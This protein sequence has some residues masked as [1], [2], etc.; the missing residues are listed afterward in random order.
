[1]GAKAKKIELYLHNGTLN[2]LTYVSESDGWDLGGI[3][4]SCPRDSVDILLNDD[5]CDK[6]GVYLLISSDKV[7]V[8]QSTDLKKRIEQHKIGK[9][10]WEKV[11]LLTSKNDELN[12]S[13]ITYLES[14]LIVKAKSCGTL[15]CENKTDGNKNN[16]DKFTKI[17]L[18]QY[19]EEAL[20]ILELIGVDVFKKGTKQSIIRSIPVNSEEKIEMRAKGE[21]LQFLENKGIK[22]GKTR[23]YAKYQEKKNLFWANPLVEYTKKEWWIILNDQVDKEIHILKVPA[24]TFE[25]CYPTK[26]GKLVVRK[27]KPFYIDLNLYKDTYIDKRTGCD[28]SKF[29]VNTIKY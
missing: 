17:L 25:T 3:L 10:W 13:Y 14:E 19:L 28:F 1:M 4:Y 26:K 22:I 7:Y 18:D 15:D 9:D 21:V 29:L 20:F 11:I 8:G 27:D 2:G 5:S 12:Q 23:C 24:N 6:Y 16:L